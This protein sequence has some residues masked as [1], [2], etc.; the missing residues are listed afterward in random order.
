[1]STTKKAPAAANGE[2]QVKSVDA[3]HTAGAARAPTAVA[4]DSIIIGDRCR[5]NGGAMPPESLP[6]PTCPGGALLLGLPQ[7]AALLGIGKTLAERLTAEGKMPAPMRL[8]DRRLW[9]AEEIRAW[10]NAGLPPRHSW[11]WPPPTRTRRR[12]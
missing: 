5:R 3:D 1:M 7:V 10:V 2:G 4:I 11:R 6:P 12:A 8:G 9:R